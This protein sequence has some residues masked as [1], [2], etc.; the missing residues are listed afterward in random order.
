[1]T[2]EEIKARQHIAKLAEQYQRGTPLPFERLLADYALW[3]REGLG[4]PRCRTAL[5]WVETA[6]PC[7]QEVL[8]HSTISDAEGIM[9]GRA[10]AQ[11][12]AKRPIG[13]L[14][15]HYFYERGYTM[16]EL[17]MHRQ[18]Y[19]AYRTAIRKYREP[20]PSPSQC[21]KFY[22]RIFNAFIFDIS[23]YFCLK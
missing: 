23:Q 21:E 11:A 8:K 5:S 17:A 12:K 18:F 20:N 13:W 1:M 16:R 4:V 19:R 2:A 6:E 15:Y 7:Y 9:L 3:C 22:K 10:V 14:V